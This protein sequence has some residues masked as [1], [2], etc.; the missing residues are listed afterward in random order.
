M[1]RL[2]KNHWA[3]LIV[4]TAATCMSSLAGTSRE[5]LLTLD[6]PSSSRHRRLLLAQNLLGFLDENAGSC[7][8]ASTDPPNHQPYLWHF[9]VCLGM[10]VGIHSR[11]VDASKHRGETGCSASYGSGFCIIISGH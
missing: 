2:I 8:E 6:R 11:H 7:S 10:A 5:F 1:G 4:L 9:H 3:R